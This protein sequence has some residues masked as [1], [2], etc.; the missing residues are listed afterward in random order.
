MKQAL[1]RRCRVVLTALEVSGIFFS[2]F[3][4][5][6]IPALIILDTEPLYPPRSADEAWETGDANVITAYLTK[7]AHRLLPTILTEWHT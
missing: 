5:T 3:R 4:L 6:V 1:A 7:V 2:R